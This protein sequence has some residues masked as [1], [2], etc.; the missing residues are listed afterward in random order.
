MESEVPLSVAIITKDEADNLAGCL[1]SVDFA[2]QIVVVDGGSS[3]DTAAIAASFGCEVFQEEWRGFGPQK[4]LAV[5][6]CRHAWVL[7]LD[8]DERLPRETAEA[9]KEIVCNSPI[10]AGYSF[11][12]KNYFQGRWIRHAGWWPDRVVRLFRKERGRLSTALVHEGLEIDGRVI[13]LVLPLEHFTES[14]LGAV[15]K[16]ID[17]YSTLGAQ[18]AFLSGKKATVWGAACRACLTFFQGYILRLG[19][20]DGPQ[21]FTLAITD[22][23][24]KF[25]KYAKLAELHK[26]GRFGG[27]SL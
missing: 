3:D 7:I 2:G 11:P 19:F 1:Q 22:A 9:I 10:A 21:G 20:L 24:N 27:M 5:D 16:K 8:A 25:F 12:R 13:P 26:R 17:H 14:R 6:R 4:Q 18:E 15:L 23:V